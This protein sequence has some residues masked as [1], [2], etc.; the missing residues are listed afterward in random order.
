MN[1]TIATYVMCN[2]LS[3]NIKDIEHGIED[4]VIWYW[5]DEKKLHK[6]KIYISTKGC[7]FMV[8][9]VRYYL[10]EFCRI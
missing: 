1:N 4:K 9:K 5:S 7:Y 3:I 10:S 6:S 8:N 2:N